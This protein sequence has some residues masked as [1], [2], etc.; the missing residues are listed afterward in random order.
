LCGAVS[1]RREKLG[2]LAGLPEI[3]GCCHRVGAQLDQD[4]RVPFGPDQYLDIEPVTG[5]LGP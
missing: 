5:E 4:R 3:D 1:E 2:C